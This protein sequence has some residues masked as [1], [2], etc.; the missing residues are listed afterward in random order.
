MDVNV[1][2][3]LR[4]FTQHQFLGNRFAMPLPVLELLLTHQV[5]PDQQG[6]FVIMM[7]RAW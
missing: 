6:H 3:N 7:D 1:Y 2:T 4:L 5:G